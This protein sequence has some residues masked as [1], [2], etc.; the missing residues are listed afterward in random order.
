LLP[1]SFSRH[2]K[3]AAFSQNFTKLHKKSQNCFYS[4][5]R[6]QNEFIA[7][8]A[9]KTPKADEKATIQSGYIF[10]ANIFTETRPNNALTEECKLVAMNQSYLRYEWR[11]FKFSSHF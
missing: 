4:V 3:T 9:Q 5:T 10:F 1:Q 11:F 2:K 6:C 8:F 7:F